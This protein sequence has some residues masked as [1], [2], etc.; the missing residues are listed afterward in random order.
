MPANWR[1][2][3]PRF[4]DPQPQ[5]SHALQP[6]DAH[7]E[8]RL[9]VLCAPALP[10][11]S[12][13]LRSLLDA[14]VPDL[15]A[16]TEVIRGDIG[17]SLHLIQSAT[18]EL[19]KD[20]AEALRLSASVVRV[21]LKQLTALVNETPLLFTHPKGK[22]GFQTCNRFWMHARLTALIAEQLATQKANVNP[23]EAY[24]AG[25][26]RHL[27]AIPFVLGWNI[28]ALDQ[29][30]PGECAFL[31]AKNWQLPEALVEVAHGIPE[32]CSSSDSLALLDVV[33]VADKHAF[34]LEL[35]CDF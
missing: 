32:L 16:V 15:N 12:V 35:G 19:G 2:S 3:Q 14:R 31:L 22:A 18:Q 25:L 6:A 9:R 27:G 1:A 29:A 5:P 24:T 20:S 8:N 21:G 11:A 23:E 33:T 26:L 7:I 13:R 28:P 4:T 10:E 34:R 30:D 17:L